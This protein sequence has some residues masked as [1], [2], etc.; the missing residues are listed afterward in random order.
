MEYETAL[1]IMGRKQQ[2]DLEKY[3]R[4]KGKGFMGLDRNVKMG[5]YLSFKSGFG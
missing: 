2:P 3:E 4:R 5:V 1:E